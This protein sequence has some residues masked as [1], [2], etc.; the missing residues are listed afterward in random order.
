MRPLVVGIALVVASLPAQA[1]RCIASVY[2]TKDH[3]QNGTQTASGIPLND[4]LPTIAHKTRPLRKTARVTNLANGRAADFKVTD[5]GPYIAG[6]C[7]DLSHA[8]AREIGCDGLCP[9][10]V[11]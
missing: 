7:V 10:T 9:V 5:R 6:R 8:A 2:G 4:N 11:E 1:E 3:D